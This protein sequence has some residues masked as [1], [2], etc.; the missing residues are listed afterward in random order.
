M[1]FMHI[2]DLHIAEKSNRYGLNDILKIFTKTTKKDKL[3]LFTTHDV[4]KLES[5]VDILTNYYKLNNNYI[6]FVIITGDIATSASSKD[7][8]FSSRLISNNV[9]VNPYEHIDIDIDFDVDIS[10]ITKEEDLNLLEKVKDG[11]K[12]SIILSHSNILLLPGNHDRNYADK[13][14]F[15][16]S[17][18]YTNDDFSHH[19]NKYWKPK[20]KTTN[21]IH[22]QLL[23]VNNSSKKLVF[24]KVDCS[25]DKAMMPYTEV[26][27][28][29]FSLDIESDLE[30]V[31]QNI[32]TDKD[33]E[34]LVPI[35][36][37][38]YLPERSVNWSLALSRW[39]KLISLLCKFNI[40]HLFCGHTHFNKKYEIKGINVHCSSST[41]STKDK[42]SRINIFQY[43]S[44]NDEVKIESHYYW[45]KKFKKFELLV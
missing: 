2:S 45:E 25:L 14:T 7:L 37:I 6:D 36:L 9:K 29:E 32:S 8:I 4:L 34:N 41:L 44:S 22:T 1:R 12:K 35:I 19:F 21:R 10:S 38:H 16:T 39:N 5:V 24:I 13:S 26:G 3:G 27:I 28:G 17:H 33:F 40:K 15:L 31:L 42:K 43:D 23:N 18:F 20:I 11:L 30:K